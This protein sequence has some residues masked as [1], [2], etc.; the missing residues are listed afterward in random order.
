MINQYIGGYDD[1]LR[2]R[3]VEIAAKVNASTIDSGQSA[4]NN[5]GG[6]QET[7]LQSYSVSWICCRQRSSVLETEIGEI[8]EQM[9]QAD[10]YQSERSITAAI[11]KNL[12]DLQQQLNHCYQR[13]ELLEAQ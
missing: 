2:Q 13:W 8:S 6:D 7:L 11:E 3:K 5:T 9:N 1:W 10:F 4:G 12:G